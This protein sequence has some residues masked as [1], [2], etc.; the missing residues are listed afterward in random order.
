MGY[1]GTILIGTALLMLP[2]ASYGEPLS[3]LDSLFTATSATCVT[4]L[5]VVD[6]GTYFT[7]FG[8]LVIILLIQMGGI[9]FMVIA[10]F[11][12][13]ALKRKISL[14][15]RLTLAESMG[16]N[17]LQ[18]VVRL[19][20]AAVRL[21]LLIEL[22]GAI[23]FSLRFIPAFGFAKGIWYSIFHSISAFCNAGF[24]IMGHYAS[25]TDYALDP[26][27]NFT[28]IALITFGGFGFAVLLDLFG[29]RQHNGLTQKRRLAL[30][31]KVVLIISA[32]LFFFGAAA[33]FLFEANNPETM[34]ELT[35]PQQAMASLFQS[36]TC[37]SAGFNTLY[38]D[39]L[40]TPS[41]FI[42]VM[43]MFIGAAPASTAGGIKVTT[44]AVMLLTVRSF[45]KSK[46]DIEAF[47][48]RISNVTVRR[49]LSIFMIGAA[50]VVV[51]ATVISF[52]EGLTTHSFL[53]QLYEIVSAFGNVGLSTGFTGNA[54]SV[55]RLILTMLM[56]AGRVGTITLALAFSGKELTSNVRY[57]EEYIMVG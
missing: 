52:T 50:L 26:I 2:A 15:E 6:T 33:F 28:S 11:L 55:T 1:L 31:T 54:T 21:S 56:Y 42:C 32:F 39:M 51:S 12:L 53:D 3:F 22:C 13:M 4:G 41:K 23:L 49:A 36:A 16:E 47:G 20:G 24:D 17:R 18:G 8:Q 37:R 14:R 29:P 7:F 44:F 38:Q 10:T 30:H 34:K 35:F 25:F 27:I 5:S 48:R 9:G 57:P 19:A 45:I 46:E 40:T 43:L